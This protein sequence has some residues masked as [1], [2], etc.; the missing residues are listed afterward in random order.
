VE[1]LAAAGDRGEQPLLI[2]LLA[3][4]GCAFAIRWKNRLG[5]DDALDVVGVHFVG[6]WI[7]TLALGF[8]STDVT[9]PLAN[10]GI[11][12]GGG[13]RYGGWNLL[14]HQVPKGEGGDA[15]MVTSAPVQR[16]SS[17]G[18]RAMARCSAACRF[19]RCPAPR[20]H[21]RRPAGSGPRRLPAS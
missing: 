5:Y 9:N 14:L 15:K 10:N 18:C 1:H 7:G 19:R 20:R 16:A 11:L 6:G 8:F 21:S 3:G 12:Y 4:V 13:G 17:C 2:G